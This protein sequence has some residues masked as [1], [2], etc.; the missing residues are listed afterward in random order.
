MIGIRSIPCSKDCTGS[1]AFN[2]NGFAQTVPGQPELLLLDCALCPVERVETAR[3]YRNLCYDPK[4]N[5]YWAQAEG[6]PGIL[7]QLGGDFS[8]WRSLPLIGS[9]GHRIQGMSCDP[10]SG[11]LLLAFPGSVEEVD[12]QSGVCTKIP[13]RDNSHLN[14][15]IAALCSGYL[16]IYLKGGLLYLSAQCPGCGKPAVFRLPGDYSPRTLFLQEIGE[17]EDCTTYQATLLLSQ[18]GHTALAQ[19]QL[20]ISCAEDVAPLPGPGPEPWPLPPRPCPC[21]GP[22]PSPCPVPPC[23]GP[24]PCPCPV[25]PCPCPVPPCPCPV[26]PC[27]CPVP[28]C[29]GPHPIPSCSCGKYEILHSIALEEAGIAHI[30]NAEGEKLQRAV[31]ESGSICELLAVNESVKRMV[32]QITIL[33]GQLYS[34]L[35]ALSC[36]CKEE[37]PEPCPCPGPQPCPCPCPKPHPCDCQS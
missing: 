37:E 22:H 1:L 13:T 4:G 6:E 5:C 8:Q 31:A 28:P 19:M 15:G 21:P 26:P 10:C 24:H 29:P 20:L 2:G 9:C 36:V 3:P 23:P 33:E 34:K 25:P 30:L 11:A 35:E 7:Y 32:T 12:T 18:W 27:P 17:E 16:L 14:L